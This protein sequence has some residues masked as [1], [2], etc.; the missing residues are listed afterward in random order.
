MSTTNDSSSEV[1]LPLVGNDITSNHP[2]TEIEPTNP[3]IPLTEPF[4]P[5]QPRTS[6]QSLQLSQ[7][8]QPSS[9]VYQRPSCND[10][11]DFDNNNLISQSQLEEP[12]DPDEDDFIPLF[13]EDQKYYVLK[14]YC[15]PTSK[16]TIGSCR[17]PHRFCV[18]A[19]TKLLTSGNQ[20][21]DISESVYC[22]DPSEKKQMHYQKLDARVLKCALPTCMDY[23][24]NQS[25]IFHFCCYAH[26]V[27]TKRGEG[28]TMV[29]CSGLDDVL[30]DHIAKSDTTLKDRILTFSKSDGVLVFPLCTKRCYNSLAV[31]RHK[32]KKQVEKSS[33]KNHRNNAKAK[34]SVSIDNPSTANWDRDGGNGKKPSIV[35]LVD[36]ITTE[37][38]L[39]KYYGGLDSEGNTNGNRKDGYHKILAALIKNENGK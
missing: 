38:N 9:S 37:G 3:T 34:K 31:S 24:T 35:V 17:F 23:A 14:E 2:A 28:L 32:H 29:Q 10:V 21:T 4:Q 30:V 36:W 27:A 7:Q 6:I 1:P 12:Y 19:R 16:I 8:T 13:H 20:L 39:T 25:K 26:D 22:P 18:V 15:L 11:S 5:I 33:N